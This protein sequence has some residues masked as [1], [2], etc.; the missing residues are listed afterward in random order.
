LNHT[1]N[2]NH[3]VFKSSNLDS[4]DVPLNVPTLDMQIKSNHADSG[5][6]SE[7]DDEEMLAASSTDSS[8]DDTE[9][10][11]ETEPDTEFE[12][13][14]AKSISLEQSNEWKDYSCSSEDDMHGSSVSQSKSDIDQLLPKVGSDYE[15]SDDNEFTEYLSLEQ[16]VSLNQ[17]VSDS[18][19]SELY[20]DEGIPTDSD[21]RTQTIL[22]DTLASLSPKN[23]ARIKLTDLPQSLC[24]TDSDVPYVRM[25]SKRKPR[26]PRVKTEG[27]LSM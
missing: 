25:R 4:E 20:M 23:P 8:D 14:P 15:L 16:L 7:P 21:Q 22:Q 18:D 24:S 11:E 12:N 27:P 13:V 9:T 6:S 17:L 19:D 10:D 2:A 1:A 26:K 3:M 5:S